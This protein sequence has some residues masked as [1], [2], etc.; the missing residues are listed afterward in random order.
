[1]FTLLLL[2]MIDVTKFQLIVERF[3]NEQNLPVLDKPKYL[4]PFE[5]TMRSLVTI[6]RY[7]ILTHIEII[8]SFYPHSN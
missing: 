5:M 8:E 7:E 1:M 3:K 2:N 4:V 6:L